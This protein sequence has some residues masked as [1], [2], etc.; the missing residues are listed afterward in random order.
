VKA[1]IKVGYTCNNNCCFCHS[2]DHTD[3]PDLT[4]TELVRKIDLAANSGHQMVVLSG[5]E[6]TIRPD[7]LAVA[8]HAARRGL[9]F[10]LVTNGRMLSYAALLERLLACRLRYVHI[11]LHGD[12][13]VHDAIVET[14][15]HAESIAGARAAATRGLHPTI[16]CVVTRR[17]IGHLRALVDLFTPEDA[18]VVK[19]SMVEAKGRALERF[20]EIVPTVT[21]AAAAVVDA[22]DYARTRGLPARHDGVPL[23]LLPGQESLIDDLVANGFRTMSEACEKDLFPV[24][25]GNKTKPPDACSGCAYEARCPGLFVGYHARHGAGEL[26]RA[27]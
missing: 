27:R 3:D 25:D 12:R 9:D 5:G 22:I 11:S 14:C 15:S 18:L 24:D 13:E 7:L 4:T 6:P 19:F 10:G 17:N 1:L 23:C 8:G 16:N 21:E 26:R 20:D 2:T